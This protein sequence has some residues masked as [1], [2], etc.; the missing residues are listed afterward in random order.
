[1]RKK[2]CHF[3]FALSELFLSVRSQTFLS[4]NT[5]VDVRPIWL[6]LGFRPIYLWI[7]SYQ[8][9]KRILTA[10]FVQCTTSL[11]CD[12]NLLEPTID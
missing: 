2:I 1:L 12:H 6:P 7:A 8:A 3:F 11:E 9:K 10:W 4:C 5:L